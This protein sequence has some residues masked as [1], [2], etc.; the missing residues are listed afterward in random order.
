MQAR[1][2]LGTRVLNS[3]AETW[4]QKYKIFSLKS[5][6]E[7]KTE[8]HQRLKDTKNNWV[9]EI[10]DLVGVATGQ[11]L[12]VVPYKVTTEMHQ[13]PTNDYSANEIKTK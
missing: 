5:F 6:T 12:N 4:R 2:L 13:I 7:D 11:C 10:K 9:D 8:L 3:L 1:N